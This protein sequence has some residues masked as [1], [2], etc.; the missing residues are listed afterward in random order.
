MI[1]K[2]RIKD[3]HALGIKKYRDNEQLFVAEG[4]KIVL[5]FLHVFQ[6]TYLVATKEWLSSTPS[7]LLENVKAIEEATTEELHK[8]SLMQTPQHV[9]AIFK[10]PK[11][12]PFQTSMAQTDICLALDGV[13]DPGNVGTILRIA[14]WFGIEN[15]LCSPDTAD[16]FSPK[17]VQASMG[18]LCRI[19]TYRINLPEILS[20]VSGN[21]PI[22]GTF[23]NGENIHQQELSNKGII[24]MGNEGNGIRKDTEQYIDTRLFVPSYPPERPTSESLNVA[25]ATAIICEEFRRR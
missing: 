14:D 20:Q 3:I 22:Y 5:E 16:V 19:K 8:A 21:A 24:I 12:I 23:L 7:S 17:V 2:K 13:Q 10:K 9:V 1:S 4:P 15:I 25:I 11:P 18:A 6:C